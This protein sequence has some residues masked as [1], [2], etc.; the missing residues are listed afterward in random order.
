[1]QYDPES[2]IARLEITSGDISYAKEVNGTIIHMTGA[3]FPVYIEILNAG[4]MIGKLGKIKST[5]PKV[6]PAPSVS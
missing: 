3:G 4:S 2:N 5:G 1:M 6:N